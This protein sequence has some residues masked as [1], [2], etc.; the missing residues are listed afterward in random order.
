MFS[1]FDL[2]TEFVLNHWLIKNISSL[3]KSNTTIYYYFYFLFVARTPVEDQL[4]VNI[5]TSNVDENCKLL[6][7]CLLD[8]L[9]IFLLILLVWKKKVIET[10]TLIKHQN[11]QILKQLDQ[12]KQKP[13]FLLPDLPV[14]IPLKQI[15]D[16][17]ILE[18]YL[19]ESEH[20]KALVRHFYNYL[21]VFVNNFTN[22]L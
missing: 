19:Q 21:V 16:I 11:D 2:E 22:F 18:N 9:K 8:A 13:H 5:P 17:Q 1:K 3:K 20:L 14:E 4:L 6:P 15:E 7:T 12:N 10:L